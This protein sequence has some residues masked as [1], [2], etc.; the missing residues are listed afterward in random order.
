MTKDTEFL[1]VES[2]VIQEHTMMQNTQSTERLKN[3]E[4]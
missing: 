3:G 2:Q 4:E 1:G